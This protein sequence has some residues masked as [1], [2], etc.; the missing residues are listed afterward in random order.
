[1]NDLDEGTVQATVRTGTGRNTV[2]AG[3][4]DKVKLPR[5]L[6][7]GV[8]FEGRHHSPLDRILGEFDR[9]LRTLAAPALGTRPNPARGL[10]EA[11]LD[12]QARQHTARLMRINH[13]GEICAQALYQGQA[14]TA[15]ISANRDALRGASAEEV[16]HLAWCEA[17]IGELGGRTSFLNLFWYAGSLALGVAA[18][19]AGDRWSLAF[20]K[21]TERQVGGHLAGHL[22]QIPAADQRTRAIVEQM[23]KDEAGHA[24][25]AQRL[26]AAEFSPSLKWA[27]R[28]S[29]KLMTRSVY[30]V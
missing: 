20:L 28:L 22:A 29:S 16:D 19:L 18:G 10:P 7:A 13:T 12:A 5:G 3:F 21:E 6:F 2:L 15:R 4:M 14:L 8:E 23:K 11:D 26:G 9:A 17:R 27:M 24:E 1:M 25:L 30:W